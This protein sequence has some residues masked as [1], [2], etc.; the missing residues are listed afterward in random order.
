MPRCYLKTSSLS[1]KLVL[2]VVGVASSH[3]DRGKIPLS[4]E[5]NLLVDELA[6]PAP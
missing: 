2:L 4:P 6:D 1:S 3:D 5:Q